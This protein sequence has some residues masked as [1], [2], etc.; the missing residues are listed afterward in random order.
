MRST[1]FTASL[2]ATALIA[3]SGVVTA[4]VPVQTASAATTAVTLVGDLQTELG[5][6]EDWAPAC[7]ASG[8]ADA[9]GDGVWTADFTVPAGDW[10]SRSPS[11][12]PGTRPT[13][14]PTATG[15]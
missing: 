6:A 15:R 10:S 7:A 1:R 11:T 13:A 3:A 9:D 5:C 12:R 4:A 14:L 8:L 2:A